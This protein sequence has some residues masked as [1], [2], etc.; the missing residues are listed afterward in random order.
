L[1]KASHELRT[2]QFRRRSLLAC[3]H[4]DS[5]AGKVALG[6]N[7]VV[8]VALAL[9]LTQVTADEPVMVD[10]QDFT[11]TPCEYRRTP[12]PGNP[13]RQPA[14]TDNEVLDSGRISLT[15]ASGVLIEATVSLVVVSPR[16]DKA[17]SEKRVIIEY[18]SGVHERR[19]KRTRE[20]VYAQLASVAAE[21]GVA[22]TDVAAC[23]PASDRCQVSS[24]YQLADD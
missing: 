7:I 10:P 17:A 5:R 15:L 24:F 12:C 16:G 6:G 19:S 13:T 14:T 4:W 23:R 20:A 22:R 21:Y 1:Y 11:R 8:G 2:D 9:G 3:E 18:E